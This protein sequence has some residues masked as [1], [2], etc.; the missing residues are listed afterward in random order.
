VH[1]SSPVFFYLSA[2]RSS[3]EDAA[4]GKTSGVTGISAV[5]KS[6]EYV[7]PGNA[8]LPN[9][10]LAFSETVAIAAKVPTSAGMSARRSAGATQGV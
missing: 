5:G 8:I 3:V 4:P 9:G 1:V 10:D 2:L 7:F 6:G